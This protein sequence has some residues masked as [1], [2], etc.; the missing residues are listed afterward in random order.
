MDE[1]G[2]A[3]YFLSYDSFVLVDGE[4]I[5]PGKEYDMKEKVLGCFY[6]KPN[7]P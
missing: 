2:F 5:E 4:P 7:Y 1:Q 3:D 6:V